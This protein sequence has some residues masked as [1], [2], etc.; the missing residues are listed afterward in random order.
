MALV[1]AGVDD[2]RHD[3]PAAS[4]SALDHRAPRP[5]DPRPERSEAP[6][7]TASRRGAILAAWVRAPFGWWL[8]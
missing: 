6:F 8:T 2:N 4:R 5:T 7:G 1:T 3:G